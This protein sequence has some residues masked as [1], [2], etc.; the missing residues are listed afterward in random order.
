MDAAGWAGR[1]TGGS[2][3]LAYVLA[4][5]LGYLRGLSH[6]ESGL[7]VEVL[8]VAPA[9]PVLPTPVREAGSSLAGLL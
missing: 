2:V 4:H 8:V 3:D 7:M 9:S 6:T 1:V 5:E